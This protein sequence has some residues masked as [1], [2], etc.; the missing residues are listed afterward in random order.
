MSRIETF[1][2]DPFKPVD[3]IPSQIRFSKLDFVLTRFL[4]SP[5]KIVCVD[6]SL[7]SNG[8]AFASSLRKTI[9]NR[10]Y[11]GV[12]VILRKGRVYLQKI[13]VEEKEGERRHEYL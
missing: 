4:E 7:Y 2:P 1:K 9:K 11:R 5:H 8:Y 12:K 10:G 13:G 6:D 3:K